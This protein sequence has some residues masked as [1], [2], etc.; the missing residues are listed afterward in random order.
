MSTKTYTFRKS[1][2]WAWAPGLLV[3]ELPVGSN[4]LEKESTH[5]GSALLVFFKYVAIVLQGHRQLFKDKYCILTFFE[6]NAQDIDCM[7][8][9]TCMNCKYVKFV[10]KSQGFH[11][12][13][14]DQ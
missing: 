10:R 11:S 9:I 2:N 5:E 6:N 13:F 14:V 7:C 8:I 1:I 4:L 12:I 3:E